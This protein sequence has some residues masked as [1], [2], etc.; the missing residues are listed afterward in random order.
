MCACMRARAWTY[1]Q[2]NATR[3]K[4][5]ECEL[6]TEKVAGGIAET[7]RASLEALCFAGVSRASERA[8]VARERVTR[9]ER[10][11]ERESDRER[12]DR[13]AEEET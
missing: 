12:G 10:A 11:N 1:T 3:N 9:A 6:R 8:R 13:R 4:E 5:R 2:H 7:R